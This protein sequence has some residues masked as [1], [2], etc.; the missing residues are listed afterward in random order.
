[1]SNLV[2]ESSPTAISLKP[3]VAKNCPNI[4]SLKEDE[5]LLSMVPIDVAIS[6]AKYL[7]FYA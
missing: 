3:E 1:M 5:P 7:F 2:D 4:D 6:K